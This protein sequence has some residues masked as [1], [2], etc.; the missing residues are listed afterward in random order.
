MSRIED[1]LSYWFGSGSQPVGPER[2]QFWFRG[3]EAVDREIRER[4]G[5][6]VEQARAG[7]LDDW[8][9]TARGRLALIIL[10]DQ[11]SRNMYRGS[12]EAFS[13]DPKAVQLTLEGVDNEHYA[14]LNCFEQLFFCMPLT[15]AEDL[16]LQERGVA[17]CEAWAAA[18]PPES[19]GFGPGALAQ[20]RLHRD[21]IARFGRFPTRNPVLGRSST[22]EEEAHVHEAKTAGKAV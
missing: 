10:I 11:F 20:A 6:D 15:H 22:P 4:F 1:V 3:G 14:A 19:K 12:A 8:A 7:A 17:L 9:R 21:V 2:F 5:A 18:L 13:Q 16:A